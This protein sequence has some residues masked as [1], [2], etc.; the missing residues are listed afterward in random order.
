MTWE[1]QQ[2][3]AREEGIAIGEERGKRE[4]AIEAA[5]NLLKM[6]LGTVEQ[7]AQAEGL[8]VDEVLELQKELN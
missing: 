2:T 5:T 3:Y 6:K 7:I 8:T 1:R 4:K